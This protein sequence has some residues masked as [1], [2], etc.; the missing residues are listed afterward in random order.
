M[1][2]LSE[3]RGRDANYNNC[4]VHMFLGVPLVVVLF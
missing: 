4:N 2:E 3:A 1:E